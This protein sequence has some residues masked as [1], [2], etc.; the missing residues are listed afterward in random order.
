MIEFQRRMK[1]LV[2]V[3]LVKSTEYS[4]RIRDIDEKV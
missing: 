4:A 3:E 1:A 2:D